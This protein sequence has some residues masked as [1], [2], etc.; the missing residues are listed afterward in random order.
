MRAILPGGPLDAY[1]C[2]MD[3][4]ALPT[5]LERFAAEAVAAGRY[6]DVAEVVA[7]GVRLLQQAEAEMVEF[8][9]SLD[10]AKAEA[11]REGWVSL[12]NMLTE[13]DQIIRERA[14]RAA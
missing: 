12:D 11:D 7:A 10:E 5:E 2:P 3:N 8:V 9:R 4:V 13:M 14:D 1:D 6:R